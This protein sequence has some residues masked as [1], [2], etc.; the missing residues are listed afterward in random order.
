M[1]ENLQNNPF[2]KVFDETHPIPAGGKANA[3]DSAAKPQDASSNE[4]PA[5]NQPST[6]SVKETE[7]SQDIGE[8]SQ[9]ADKTDQS[10]ESAETQ[11]PDTPVTEE[12]ARKRG[13][14]KKDAGDGDRDTVEKPYRFFCYCDK[15][16]IDQVRAIARKENMT[17]R[18]V[19]EKMLS[20]CIGKYEK[21]FGDIPVKEK[22]HSP[23]E[24]F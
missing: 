23:D 11:T 4:A 16:L 17:I 24:L 5:D 8:A 9:D 15:I 1:E 3:A 10:M 20:K 2:G 6:Q 22:S 18:A 12:P 14:K 21:K 19:V 13:R 7:S